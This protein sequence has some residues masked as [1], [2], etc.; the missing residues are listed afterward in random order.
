MKFQDLLNNRSSVSKHTHRRIPKPMMKSELFVLSW[1]VYPRRILLYLSEKQFPSSLITI[2]PCTISTQG[3]LE[4]P[5]KPAGT[6]PILS[7]E[8]GS[9]IRQSVAIL[10]HLE[11]LYD[12]ELGQSHHGDSHS[13]IGNT[14]LERAVT[15]EILAL[16]DEATTH[17]G[18]S[19]HKGRALFTPLEAQSVVAAEFALEAL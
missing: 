17:F 2:T 7:L 10:Y 8:D 16:A 3:A 14:P 12:S 6:V 15:R 5:G 9:H 13:F 19:C 1:G 18:V 4:A 11:E